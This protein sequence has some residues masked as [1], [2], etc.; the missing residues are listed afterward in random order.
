[1]LKF[2]YKA[3]FSSLFLGIS[4]L[5]ISI[6]AINMQASDIRR[7]MKSGSDYVYVIRLNNGDMLTG[8]IVEFTSTVEDGEGIRFKTE[9]G[10]ATI[11]VNQIAEIELKEIRYKH[12]HRV[13][14]LPTAEPIGNNFFAGIFELLFLY[15]GVG[16]ENLSV[17]AGRS[18]VPAV[19]SRD[20]ISAINV[21]Y[22]LLNFPFEDFDG[23][24]SF[25][26]GGN[27]SY[28]NSKNQLIHGFAVATF[29]GPK[30][31]ITGNVFFKQGNQ[32]YYVVNFGRN[33]VD[34]IYEDG[35]F[36][37]ALGLD[38]K[39]SSRHDLHFIGELWNNN[40]TKPTNTGVLLGFRLWN[41]S[42]SSDFGIAF[43][44]QPFL[45]PFVSFAWTPF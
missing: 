5:S 3:P 42:F 29:R 41:T 35:A 21:K 2:N 34:M 16:F 37:I 23:G 15:G 11:F 30:S 10:T 44:T 25:A 4:F 22:T 38:T 45:V 19:D 40:V 13:F 9:L 24:L 39:F 1:M 8:T 20:Q 26:I 14:L 7:D 36:G 43:F 31:Y 12:A 27:L 33:A 6:L 32:D 17:T 28:A 18:M